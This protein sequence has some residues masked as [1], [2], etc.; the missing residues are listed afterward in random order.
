MPD[1]AVIPPTTNDQIL[2]PDEPS[3][4]IHY[5]GVGNSQSV[6]SG[7]V[8]QENPPQGAEDVPFPGSLLRPNEIS[9]LLTKGRFIGR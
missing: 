9:G 8:T 1:S 7:A 4:S 6:L 3:Q 5:G 2:R